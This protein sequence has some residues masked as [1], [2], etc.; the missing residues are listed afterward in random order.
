MA[1]TR[2][3][4]LH[5]FTRELA[6]QKFE[7]VVGG[8]ENQDFP[9]LQ[10]LGAD[11]PCLSRSIGEDADLVPRRRSHMGKAVLSHIAT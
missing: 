9:S 11:I 3:V 1:C 10:V 2:G 6:L 8:L 5:R 7:C 4:L